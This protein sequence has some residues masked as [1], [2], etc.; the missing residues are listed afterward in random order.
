MVKDLRITSFIDAIEFTNK[1]TDNCF[2]PIRDL[3]DDLVLMKYKGLNI[4]I[5]K[6]SVKSL[7]KDGTL[8]VEVIR[9]GQER[10]RLLSE[11]T[12]TRRICR[13]ILRNTADLKWESGVTQTID[14]IN[15]LAKGDWYIAGFWN[16]Y[17]ESLITSHNSIIKTS[18]R[19][20]DPLRIQ[21][22]INKDLSNLLTSIEVVK[23]NAH[24]SA[25][26]KTLE[27]GY[28]GKDKSQGVIVSNLPTT[29]L[30]IVQKVFHTKAIEMGYDII[31]TSKG[32]PGRRVIYSGLGYIPSQAI[33]GIWPNFDCPQR[34]R[35][36]MFSAIPNAQEFTN[37]SQSKPLVVNKLGEPKFLKN[38]VKFLN[39]AVFSF[40]EIVP[41]INGEPINADQVLGSAWLRVENTLGTVEEINIREYQHEPGMDEE[42][43]Q[44]KHP[45]CAVT[46]TVRPQGGMFEIKYTVSS[47]KEQDCK[48]AYKVVTPDAVKGMVIPEK[49]YW[50][51]K[52]NNED[53]FRPIY[54]FF[55]QEAVIKK[56]AQ[57]MLLRMLKS[58]VSLPEYRNNIDHTIPR[59][60]FANEIA[61]TLNQLEFQGDN[62]YSQIFEF[63]P[64]NGEQI[65]I[66][67][68]TQEETKII[69]YDNIGNISGKLIAI[70]NEEGENA[71]SIVG[72]VAVMRMPEDEEFGNPQRNE[73]NHNGIRMDPFLWCGKDLDKEEDE[74]T[75]H[76]IN[77]LVALYHTIDKIPIAVNLE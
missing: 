18:T 6:P 65:R 66:L 5:T 69:P 43:I 26:C 47:I 67:G 52:R 72:E 59:K 17:A 51:E 34:A 10:K 19:K 25:H 37:D 55:A 14:L 38:R 62:G 21:S 22:K 30:A 39:C 61:D 7:S 27:L 4:E 29:A 54:L 20:L 2:I 64:G 68:F 36:E 23:S 58:R 75:K 31:A 32:H 41:N 11:E 35:R 48:M 73:E 8:M 13:P 16:L 24:L 76:H 1:I 71:I 12:R 45:N 15:N 28:P 74:S 40:N 3:D 33:L 46:R 42:E 53:F 9:T 44:K 77:S 60:M 49:R 50:I 63:I 57:R 70:N 56:E